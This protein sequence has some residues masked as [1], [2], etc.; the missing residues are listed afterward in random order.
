MPD[1]PGTLKPPRLPSA[2]ASP[3]VGQMYYDTTLNQLLYWNG[4][5][6]A[7]SSASVDY[8]HYKGDW[9][10]GSYVDG[11]IVIYQGVE[12][13]CVRPTSA[14]PT[15]WPGVSGAATLVTGTGAPSNAFGADGAIYIDLTAGKLEFYGPK[16]AG[17]WPAS[18]F[19]KL[20][21]VV[22]LYDD[23]RQ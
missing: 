5:V 6:W 20:L 21:P 12:Y 4:T 23:L 16:A 9:A 13:L 17:A 11:D 15:V 2:P 3:V 8:H 18:P 1:F 14:T 19:G 7:S 10:A 22:P